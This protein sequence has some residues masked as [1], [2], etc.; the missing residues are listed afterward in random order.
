MLYGHPSY[1]KTTIASAAAQECDLHFTSVNGP[2][3]LNKYIT[4]S[5]K[6]VSVC[7]R[8]VSCLLMADVSVRSLSM[9]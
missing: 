6:S 8:G 2:E 5:E 7:F 9:R 3:L 1:G 4:Q